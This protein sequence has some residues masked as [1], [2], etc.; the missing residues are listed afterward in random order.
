MPRA[1]RAH[2]LPPA[3]RPR[4]GRAGHHPG[5]CP[6]GPGVVPARDRPAPGPP[7]RLAGGGGLRAPGAT[8]APRPAAARATWTST[9]ASGASTGGQ[10]LRSR[11]GATALA[12]ADDRPD[13]RGRPRAPAGARVGRGA[14][15][16]D[17]ASRAVV[18]MDR[19]VRAAPY[20]ESRTCSAPWPWSLSSSVVGLAALPLARRISRPLE[21][22]TEAARRLG[23][24]DLS[25]RAPA[26]PTPA[27][28]RRWPRAGRRRDPG[29]HARVQ[30]HGRARRAARRRAR[31]SSS[32]TLARAAL[33]AGANP[34][35]ARAAPPHPPTRSACATSRPIS[36][37]WTA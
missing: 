32:P 7:R 8:G 12:P 13:P 4:G 24:G 35:G 1:L 36:T 16:R 6:R 2:L 23:A 29:A 27:G 28:R 25:A 26:P 37:S 31:R 11:G 15:V 20:G 21:R 9:S 33:A 19:G 14:P 34:R 22:L 10:V 17:P 18:G 3:G 5:L 30:R